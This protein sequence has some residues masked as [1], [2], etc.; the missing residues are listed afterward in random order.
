MEGL[1]P[2][3]QSDATT[4]AGEVRLAAVAVAGDKTEIIAAARKRRTL[5]PGESGA[6]SVLHL[7]VT[8]LIIG[9]LH[10]F[11]R[12]RVGGGTEVSMES[13]EG[14]P[15]QDSPHG[16]FIEGG[17]CRNSGRHPHRKHIPSV[18]L[19]RRFVSV[20]NNHPCRESFPP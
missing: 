18:P 2:E 20:R 14:C 17:H 12:N 19:S 5:P 15:L 8:R 1:D 9:V 4:V 11:S 7:R 16:L 13:E 6:T 10:S 3:A